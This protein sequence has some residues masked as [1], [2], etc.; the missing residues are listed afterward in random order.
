MS[1]HCII[2]RFILEMNLAALK[3]VDREGRRQQSPTSR[4]IP[5]PVRYTKINVDAALSKGSTVGSVA[6]A[7]RDDCGMFLGAFVVWCC[8]A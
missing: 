5:P 6:A 4:L 3:V 1:T 8:H 7:A 2:D